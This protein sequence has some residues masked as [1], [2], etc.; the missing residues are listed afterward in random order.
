MFRSIKIYLPLKKEKWELLVESQM[1]Y[2]LKLEWLE[3]SVTK[4]FNSMH[5]TWRVTWFHVFRHIRY[6][7]LLT[8]M[9]AVS[10]RDEPYPFF[11]FWRHHL[12]PKFV[13]S[14][15]QCWERKRSFQWYPDQIDRKSQSKFAAITRSYSMVKTARLYNALSVII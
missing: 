2:Y 12:W 7:W 4:L 5:I 13:S 3:K 8:P 15:L 6:T 14:M 11:H 10:D 9:P 1:Q